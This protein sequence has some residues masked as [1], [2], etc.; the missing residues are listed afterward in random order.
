MTNI[1]APTPRVP[2]R[3]VLLSIA[4]LWVFYFVLTSVRGSIVGLDPGMDMMVRRGFVT[5]AGIGITVLLWLLLRL[6]DS[7]ALWMKILAALILAL[8]AAVLVAQVNQLAFAPVQ[9][10]IANKMGKEWGVGVRRDEAGNI[11]IEVPFSRNAGDSMREGLGTREVLFAKVPESWERWRAIVDIALGRYFLMLAW[12]S[13]YFAFLA[14]AQTRLAERREAEFRRQ[15]KEA[16]LRSLR[17]QVNPHF[18]FN[19][20]NSLSALVMTGKKERAEE[21]IQT[22][23]NFYRYSL[24]EDPT[25]DVSL[26]EEFELQRHYLAIEEVRFPERLTGVFDLAPELAEARVPG[27]ILQPLIE[28]SVKYAVAPLKRPVTVTLSARE[29]YGRLVV[30]VADDGPGVPHGAHYGMGI[31]LANVRDRIQARFGREATINSG[32]VE[33]GYRTE[34]R[35]PLIQH[36]GSHG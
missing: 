32:P 1:A 30:S 26:A 21:M 20:L 10:A 11:F 14:V 3:T 15:A 31:G 23:S 7:R 5:L 25:N 22:I 36:G 27:M 28:N 9:G 6:F 34:L 12:A 33:G 17:Y 8:P 19:T 16:E 35:L 18:L 4:V 29:E 13:I 2:V 24:A